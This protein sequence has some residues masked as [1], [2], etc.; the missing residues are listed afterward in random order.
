[1][2]AVTLERVRKV[3][4]DRAAAHVAVHALDLTIASGEFVVLVGPSGCGKSTTLRMI[5]GLES[6]TDGIIRIGDR[7]VNDVPARDRDIAMV[8]QNYALYPHM[9][10][11]QNLSF[12]LKLRHVP[13]GDID[14]RVRD[15]ATLLGIEDL[16]AR[17]PRQLS[18][19]QRQRVAL[20]RAIVRHPQVFLFDEPLSNLDAKLRVQMRR[21]L[22]ALHRRLAATTIY[23]TH[24]QVEAM[25]LGDRIVLMRDGKVQQVG[26]PLE[27]YQRP[28]NLFT[29]GFLGSPPMNQFRGRIVQR[30]G[31][32]F[33]NP[34]QDLRIRVPDAGASLSAGSAGREV[35]L[36]LRPESLLITASDAGDLTGTVEEIEPLGH[37][38]IVMVRVGAVPVTLRCEADQAV[39]MGEAVGIA[40]ARGTHHW[41]DSGSEKRLIG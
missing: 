32:W 12:A 31:L 10:V 36:G 21:E 27:V 39:T 16:L 37:E 38:L 14:T 13:R 3:Y 23:V 28:A 40:V 15:A 35:V 26:P 33:E 34:D 22:S 4:E 17:K 2:A 25:T 7:V 29:A 9:S 20:G 6:V 41:F 19:G 5:A 30:E 8:F 1:M 24:D 11:Y 18:G